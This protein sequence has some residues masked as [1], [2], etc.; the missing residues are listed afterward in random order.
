[1]KFVVTRTS[2]WFDENP[3]I[4]GAKQEELTSLDYRT[5]AKLKTAEKQHWYKQWYDNGINHREENGMVVCD[6]KKKAKV[7][8]MK[9]N[10]LD[11]L[12]KFANKYGNL[13]MRMGDYKE[14]Q[15]V[16]EIYDGYR[17]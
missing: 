9:I 2:T 13:V 4:E 15:D 10:S 11:E 5:V 8:T 1:M 14:T 16:I 7:W 17:E 12:M 3:K 6:R